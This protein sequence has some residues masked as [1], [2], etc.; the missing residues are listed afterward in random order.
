MNVANDATYR[1]PAGVSTEKKKTLPFPAGLITASQLA[2]ETDRVDGADHGADRPVER[3]GEG[4]LAERAA[5][6]ERGVHQSF[7]TAR[8]RNDAF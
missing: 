8:K 7:F 1:I 4:D 6:V 3:D 2:D 5:A